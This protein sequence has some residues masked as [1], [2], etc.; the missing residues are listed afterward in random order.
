MSGC[1]DLWLR[2]ELE[3]QKWSIPRW[4]LAIQ[5]V[6]AMGLYLALRYSG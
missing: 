4:T 6:V 5:V 2:E 1:F 3:R